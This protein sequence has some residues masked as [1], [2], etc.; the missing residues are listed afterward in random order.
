MVLYWTF[1][2]EEIFDVIN[3][4]NSNYWELWDLVYTKK[5]AGHQYKYSISF[6]LKWYTVFSYVKWKKDIQIPTYDAVTFYG[7][8]FRLL[9]IEEIDYYI[10]SYFDIKKLKR[11]DVC[12]DIE[13]PI[14]KVW[15]KFKKPKQTWKIHLSP[16]WE[17]QWRSIG[18]YNTSKNRRVFIRLYDK[19]ADIKNSNKT[20][21]YW[22]YLQKENITRIEVEIRREHARNIDYREL[23]NTETLK[24]IF[25]NYL[26][27]HTRIFDTL[28]EE[29][30]TLYRKPKKISDDEIQSTYYKK[31][32]KASFLGYA[33]RIIQ[34]WWCPIR[35]LAWE[36][37]YLESTKIRL[38]K[39]KFEDL[40]KYEKIVKNPNY[41]PR[42]HGL[43]TIIEEYE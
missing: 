26:K 24:S 9:E 28:S 13:D 12:M 15:R 10:Q 40:V 41:H 19:I 5:K 43:K 3:T 20:K 34:L 18:E 21:L 30:I 7:T 36:W 14:E 23:Y 1:K 27:K 6:T 32:F 17:F 2:Q 25:K 8:A 33:K 37:L 39:K 38:G 35:V 4:T 42:D 31:L 22:D 16:K 29:T 11:F